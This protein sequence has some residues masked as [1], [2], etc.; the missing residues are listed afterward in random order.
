MAKKNFGKGLDAIIGGIKVEEQ[1]PINTT[2][3]PAKNKKVNLNIDPEV[4]KICKLK[5]I[6]ENLTITD[7]INKSL[8]YFLQQ[9]YNMKF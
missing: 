4:Y 1:E 6:E 5:A 9:E 8:K 7:F 3:S 2:T